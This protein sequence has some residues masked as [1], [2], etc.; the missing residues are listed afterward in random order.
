MSYPSEN[1]Q[2]MLVDGYVPPEPKG[3]Y[4]SD[5][6]EKTVAEEQST[7]EQTFIY[8]CDLVAVPYCSMQVTLC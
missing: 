6:K 2:R 4:V 1:F 3:D 8:T 7:E 5:K